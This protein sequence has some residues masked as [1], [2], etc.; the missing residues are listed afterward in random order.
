M[1]EIDQELLD[2]RVVEFNIRR[3]HLSREDYQT[4]LDGLEASDEHGEPTTTVFA[5]PY[6]DRLQNA[7]E[8]PSAD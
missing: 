4:W 5:T 1:P 3:G 6:A 7:E 8:E 2:I